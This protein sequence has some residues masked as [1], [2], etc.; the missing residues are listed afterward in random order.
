[1]A[2]INRGRFPLS[3]GRRLIWSGALVAVVAI[4]A[5]LLL[6]T[7]RPGDASGAPVGLLVGDRAPDFTLADL[8][9]KPVSLHQFLG[10][11]VLLHFWAVDCTSCQA[12]QAGYLRAIHHLGSRAPVILAEDAWGEPASYARPYV[13]KHHL[14]GIVLIDTS[15]AVFDGLYQGQGTPTAYYIDPHGIIR[16]TVI[17]PEPY[18]GILANMKTIGA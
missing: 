6:L 8:Q 3:R 9:G 4:L 5:S 10:R 7:H 13:L 14:P 17:G 16:Q 11:P 12:E 2:G 15:R 18:A 1:M